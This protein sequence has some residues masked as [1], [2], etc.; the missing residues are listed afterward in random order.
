MKGG[1]NCPEWHGW[2]GWKGE[3]YIANFIFATRIAKASGNTTNLKKVKGQSDVTYN[4]MKE[5]I[6]TFGI[7]GLSWNHVLW[8]WEY[9]KQNN[10]TQK[11]WRQI[12]IYGMAF[13]TA[14]D[15]FAHNSYYQDEATG[16]MIHIVSLG[17]GKDDD[18]EVY[19]NRW[20]CARNTGFWVVADCYLENEGSI[21][22][23]SS[24]G[25]KYWNG[26]YMGNI[27]KYAEAVNGRK[28]AKLVEEFKAVNYELP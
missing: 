15:S 2:Y 9:Y 1:S 3:N 18:R 20:K 12:F 4:R 21:I 17:D 28:D 8:E 7:N 13:H 6:S 25:E 27:L 23:F 14:T 24:W 19:A 10:K 26:F 16:N 5:S 11:R 22:D